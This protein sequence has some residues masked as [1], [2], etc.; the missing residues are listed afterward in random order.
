MLFVL[1]KC[2]NCTI[3][4]I[5]IQ[6]SLLQFQYEYIGIAAFCRKLAEYKIFLFFY[7]KVKKAIKE[8]IANQLRPAFGF[9]SLIL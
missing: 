3:S 2:N 9:V 6:H 5:F 8:Y 1:N 4:I 7:K